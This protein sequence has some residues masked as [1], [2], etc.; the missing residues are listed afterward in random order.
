MTA[1][2]TLL[3]AGTTRAL[4][5]PPSGNRIAAPAPGLLFSTIHVVILPVVAGVA[6]ERYAPRPSAAAL[7]AAPRAAVVTITLTSRRSSAPD[8]GRSSPPG[9][10][11]WGPTFFCSPGVPPRL[12]ARAADEN[13]RRHR[14]YHLVR[15]RHAELRARR[16]SRAAELR[17]P[18]G[19]DSE[20]YFVALRL[21]HRQ[22]ARLVWRRS[23]QRYQP[24]P[25]P[26]GEIPVGQ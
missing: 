1:V 9:P 19:C 14:A 26:A 17:Q 4:T 3:A 12:R 5:L 11:P 13:G 21:G 23:G 25:R 10:S 8:A 7:P 6:L 16:G 22:R 15:G 20:R 24:P 18:A 2:S